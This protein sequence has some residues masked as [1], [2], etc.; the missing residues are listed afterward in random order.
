MVLTFICAMSVAIVGRCCTDI[1]GPVAN[2]QIE[3]IGHD[4]NHRHFMLVPDKDEL[5]ASNPRIELHVSF[6]QE[7]FTHFLLR[8][9]DGRPGR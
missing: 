2:T 8:D 4:M 1:T 3:L 9:N 7:F 6:M 5:E